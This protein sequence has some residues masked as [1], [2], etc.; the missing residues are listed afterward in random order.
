M[1]EWA[2]IGVLILYTIFS[3]LTRCQINKMDSLG[4]TPI[5]LATYKSHGDT[6]QYLLS[7][8][9]DPNLPNAQGH[10]SY[11]LAPEVML[12]VLNNQSLCISPNTEIQLLEASRN[13]DLATI[14]VM[15]GA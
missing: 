7:N 1:T 15:G 13:G 11:D 12:K 10:T 14:K 8:G 2:L 3:V 5:H 4:M 9:A 6:C